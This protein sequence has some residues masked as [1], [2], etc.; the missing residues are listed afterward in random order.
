LSAFPALSADGGGHAY[1]IY[2][3]GAWNDSHPKVLLSAN[4]MGDGFAFPDKRYDNTGFRCVL[5]GKSPE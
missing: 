2:R 4:R 5:A 3:G 1:R